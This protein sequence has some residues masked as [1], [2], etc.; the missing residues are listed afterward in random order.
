MHVDFLKGLKHAGYGELFGDAADICCRGRDDRRR[1]GNV[2][3]DTIPRM[4]MQK[5]ETQQQCEQT[6]G[7][8]KEQAPEAHDGPSFQLRI[9]YVRQAATRRPHQLLDFAQSGRR[10]S[11]IKVRRPTEG[12]RILRQAVRPVATEREQ[13]GSDL[14]RRQCQQQNFRMGFA[15]VRSIVDRT[16]CNI[17]GTC[18]KFGGHAVIGGPIEREFISR[19]PHEDQKSQQQVQRTTQGATHSIFV[20]QRRSSSSNRDQAERSFPKS[21]CR[22]TRGRLDCISQDWR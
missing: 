15:T 12:G 10:R 2:C 3:E 8:N 16:F 14:D 9:G 19:S 13:E 22:C 4:E 11:E 17:A 20:R 18:T 21:Y 5:I 1:S 7:R 6:A